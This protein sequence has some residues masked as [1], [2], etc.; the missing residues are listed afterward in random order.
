MKYV[1]AKIFQ[2]IL[3]SKISTIVLIMRYLCQKCKKK[4]GI[5]DFV[6]DVTYLENFPDF[7]NLAHVNQQSPGILA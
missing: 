2:S 7:E 5:S 1:S 3:F 6:S 4:F